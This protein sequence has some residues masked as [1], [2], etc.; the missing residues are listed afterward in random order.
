MYKKDGKWGIMDFEGKE[1]TKNIY[2]SIENLQPTEGKLLVKENDK[3]GCID[4]KGNILVNTEYDNIESDG[5]YTEKSG[6][7]DSG[8]IVSNKTDDGYRYGYITNKNKVI[9]EPKYNEISRILKEDKDIY[10]IVSEN[11]KFGLYNSSKVVIPNE[12]QEISYDDNLDVLIVQKNRKYGVAKLDG[13]FVINVEKDEIIS[14]GEYLYTKVG[15]E[16]KVYDTE[17]KEVNINYNRSIYKTESDKYKISTILNNNITYYGVIDEN[18]N[19]LINEDYKYIEYLFDDYFIATNEQGSMGIIN[20]NGRIILEMKYNSLQKLKGK[21]IIQAVDTNSKLTEIYSEKM[22][23]VLSV[24]EPYITIQ[25]EYIIVTSNNEKVYLDK[26]GNQIT[27]T[28]AFEKTNYPEQLGEYT[29]QM[30]IEKV[31]YTKQ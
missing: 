7:I 15:T 8:F 24:T 21:K 23:K 2:T 3:Y 9:L 18:G 20:K 10:L 27:D 12:Y 31:Y 19:Q 14:R 29:V 22:Q 17:G 4:I 26:V 11:G 13:N 6:Y 28:E 16:Q 5:Y 30:S 1:I 25:D